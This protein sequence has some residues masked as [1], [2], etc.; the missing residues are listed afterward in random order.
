VVH[1]SGNK[2]LSGKI[3]KV[4]NGFSKCLEYGRSEAV[5]H[6]VNILMSPL[7]AKRH[8]EFLDK[9]YK[10]GKQK[11]F[12][13]ERF[14]F[15][16]NKVGHAVPVKILV[17]QLPS[18]SD[19]I[20]Y[21]GMIKPFATEYDYILTDMMGNIDSFTKGITSILGLKPDL[22]KANQTLNIQILCPDLIE[23][24]ALRRIAV[25]QNPNNPEEGDKVL[26]A[27]KFAQ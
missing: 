9:F 14:Y 18:L 5:G 15:A 12:K 16:Q 11:L 26:E 6:N 24:F 27:N 22:I 21:V 17:K 23:M 8:A 10:T 25:K 7:F 13:R 2:E 4:S 1:I 20:Q 19:G 3:L